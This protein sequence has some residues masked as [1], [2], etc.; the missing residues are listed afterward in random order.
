MLTVE[1]SDRLIEL[2][3]A[4]L[5]ELI[6]RY[7]GR[8]ITMWAR[9]PNAC[10]AAA[11]QTVRLAR[12]QT[13]VLRMLCIHDPGSRANVPSFGAAVEQLRTECRKWIDDPADAERSSLRSLC[14]EI[15]AVVAAAREV[16]DK[17]KEQ[18]NA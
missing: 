12:W 7:P 17:R 13:D 18:T 10:V 15:A 8:R 4:V 2:W 14:A 1:Q 16:W 9:V 5:V 6:A 3:A 11:R